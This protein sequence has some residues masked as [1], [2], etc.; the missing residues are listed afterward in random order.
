MNDGQLLPRGVV[1]ADAAK[2]DTQ[3]L[4]KAAQ[5]HLINAPQVLSPANRS[6]DL[7]KQVQP[8]QLRLSL[9]FCG[10]ALRD[11][12]RNLGGGNNFSLTVFHRRD[13]HGNVNSSA[14]FPN[15]HGFKMI[16]SFTVSDPR[17]DCWFLGMALGRNEHEH[18]F[19][20]GFLWG[21]PK[22][23]FCCRVPTED[24]TVQGLADDRIIR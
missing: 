17:Q 22:Q 24:D 6:G 7:V 3:V 10:L 21:I 8:Y 23:P 15:T 16:H 5:Y 14:V 13:A 20:N 2:I 9:C 18:W 1:I 12:T 4:L 11:V 19:A